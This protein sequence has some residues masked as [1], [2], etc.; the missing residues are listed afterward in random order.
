MNGRLVR[1]EDVRDHA[2]IM[3]V[4]CRT[5]LITA[6]VLAVLLLAGAALGVGLGLGLNKSDPSPKDNPAVAPSPAADSPA[7][8]PEPGV[9]MPCDSERAADLYQIEENTTVC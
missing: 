8:A 1:M 9:T 7:S 2:A 6:I 4:T 5:A 3:S